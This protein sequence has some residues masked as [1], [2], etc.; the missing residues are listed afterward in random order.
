MIGEFKV[1]TLCGSARFKDEFRKQ[2]Q[3][4]S[5]KGYIVLSPIFFDDEIQ[6]KLERTKLEMLK[7]MHYRRI[8]LSDEI[9]VINKNGY[10][11]ES[12]KKEID[13]ARNHNKK[14]RFLENY[15]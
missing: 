12:T 9:L 6:T 7:L 1:I 8:D 5:L 11:G 14:V 4:L 15:Q 3:I 10:I 13:Y 2:E